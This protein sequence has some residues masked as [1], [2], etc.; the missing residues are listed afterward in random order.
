MTKFTKYDIINVACS[1]A[2]VVNP[3]KEII[4]QISSIAACYDNISKVV[5]FGS[6]SRGDNGPRSDIDIAVYAIGDIFDFKWDLETRVSTLLEFDITVVHDG[7]DE[8]FLKQIENDG[9]TIYEKS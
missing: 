7:L 3:V 6:R 5:L 2:L 1:I 8:F 9:V 4:S